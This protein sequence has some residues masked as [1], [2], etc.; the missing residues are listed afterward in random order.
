VAVGEAVGWPTA[1]VAVREGVGVAVRLEGVAVLVPASGVALGVAVVAAP[2]GVTV[3]VGAPGSGGTAVAVPVVGVGSTVGPA[4]GSS[5]QS[6]GGMATPSNWGSGLG[7]TICSVSK[8]QVNPAGGF[9]SQ[10]IGP[11]YSRQKPSMV[12]DVSA[13]T[14]RKT[15]S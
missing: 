13:G 3:A 11:L 5:G 2:V 12:I 15:C 6:S 7:E 10:P 4:A 1:G 14:R 8:Y 9:F